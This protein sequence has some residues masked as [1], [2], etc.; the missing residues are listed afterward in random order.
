MSIFGIF[1]PN[2]LVFYVRSQQIDL[3][4][5]G[6]Y[7]ENDVASARVAIK[8]MGD[9]LA[10]QKTDLNKDGIIDKK[11]ETIANK[12]LELQKTLSKQNKQNST[13]TDTNM[14]NKDKEMLVSNAWSR[15]DC[16][17]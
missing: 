3:N 12:I 14:S 2:Q 17:A 4:N 11:D 16:M 10:G 7:D 9:L 5:D 8:N 13:D 1:D 15:F 6:V